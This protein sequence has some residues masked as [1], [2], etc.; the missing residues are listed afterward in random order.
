MGGKN[1]AAEAFTTAKMEATTGA[2]TVTLQ[3]EGPLATG[4]QAHITAI[5]KQNGKEIPADQL[6]DYLAAKAHMVIIGVKNQAYLHVHPEV[7]NN[8]LDLHTTFTDP[9]IYRGWL[10]FQAA[11]KV[12]TADFVLNIVQGQGQVESNS[13]HEHGSHAE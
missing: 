7:T 3:P 2:Y 13:H 4:S 11:G 8:R 1:R 12:Y 5:V 9:D 6:E 10:Q